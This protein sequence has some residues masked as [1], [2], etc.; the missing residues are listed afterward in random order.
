MYQRCV[1]H[2]AQEIRC[3]KRRIAR[4]KSS[5]QPA[6]R[7]PDRIIQPFWNRQPVIL[8]DRVRH[9]RIGEGYHITDAV[10]V[11]FH[12][13]LLFVEVSQMPFALETA[14]RLGFADDVE[15]FGLLD[16]VIQIVGQFVVV[17]SK[18]CVHFLFQ[19]GNFLAC[20]LR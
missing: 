12:I 14:I 16:A 10:H 15:P 8:V 9:G 6:C 11:T 5:C 20:R 7:V 17:G 13:A 19:S 3:D 2:V 4:G 1:L 18:R